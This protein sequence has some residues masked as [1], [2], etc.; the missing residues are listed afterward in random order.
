MT[1]NSSSPHLNLAVHVW[2]V[3]AVALVF[4]LFA[5][6]V[7]VWPPFLGMGTSNF[8]NF[9]MIWLPELMA[10]QSVPT[11]LNT[12]PV[13]IRVDGK[14]FVRW[15]W[16][17]R[18]QLKAVLGEELARVPE[19]VV[20]FG[21]DRRLPFGEAMNVLAEIAGLDPRS[22]VFVTAGSSSI[23]QAEFARARGGQPKPLALIRPRAEGL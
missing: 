13:T 17:P 18:E 22:V 6:F 11:D 1:S 16:I 4:A 15:R 20:L 2:P 5:Y 12:V 3:A 9:S 21:V 8:H 14:V 19:A 23:L 7:V 10:A